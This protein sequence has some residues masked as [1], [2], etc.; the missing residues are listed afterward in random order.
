M[1]TL[2]KEA[3]APRGLAETL[4]DSQPTALLNL[5]EGARQSHDGVSQ[6]FPDEDPRGIVRRNEVG[7]RRA[8]LIVRGNESGTETALLTGGLL[9]GLV[10]MLHSDDYVSLLV[11]LVDVSVS[12]GGLFQ[13]IASVNDRSHLLRLN[14]LSEENQVFSPFA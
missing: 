14:Q 1:R 5:S 8:V 10:T 7:N 6:Q 11:P 2:A 3:D 13:W 12:L 9:P 4:R